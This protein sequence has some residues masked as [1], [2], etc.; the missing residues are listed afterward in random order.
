M[1]KTSNFVERL[2]LVLIVVCIAVWVGV[3]IMAVWTLV[4]WLFTIL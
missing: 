1:G 4:N 2:A 3:I